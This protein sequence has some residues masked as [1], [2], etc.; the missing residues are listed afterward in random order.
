MLIGNSVSNYHDVERLDLCMFKLIF[1]FVIFFW[2]SDFR[3]NNT[4]LKG[5]S[6][7]WTDKGRIERSL[8][9]F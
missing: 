8:L 4:K 6:V 5:V 2:N 3:E 7:T 1:C 9:W